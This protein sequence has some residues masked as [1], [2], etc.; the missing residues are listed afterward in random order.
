[1]SSSC[2]S[3]NRFNLKA[4]IISALIFSGFL[5]LNQINIVPQVFVN[6]N[7]F[8]PVFF[9][10]GL[11]ASVSSCNGLTLSLM[12]TV[13]DSSNSFLISRI[14]S[15]AVFGSILGLVGQYFK[16]SLINVSWMFIFIYL[17]LIFNGLK[18]V[19]LD[20]SC[21]SNFRLF[22]KIPKIHP[23][24]LGCFTFF[25][26]CGF[27]FTAQTL[28]L[29]SGNFFS[30]MAIMFLFAL[31][32]T[33]PLL[34]ISI[35]RFF[36]TPF[37]TN[38]A[39]FLIIFF[40][41]FSLYRQ[42]NINRS[43]ADLAPVIDGYQVIKMTVKKDGYYPNNFKIRSDLP[44]KW[45][46]KDGGVSA[47]SNT[48]ISKSLLDSPVIVTPYSVTTKNFN[49]PKKSGVYHFSCSM[50]MFNGSIEVIN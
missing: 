47:C 12:L 41:L 13:K 36:K 7:T 50:G 3:K 15:F 40:S 24:L 9:L 43:I 35:N 32:S 19:G 30:G 29:A 1:M 18:M 14:L 44:V 26:P 2:C 23:F 28:A 34:I 17:I 31:G 42:I 10:F 16:F 8:L 6:Q 27:T 33:I 21:L 11:L 37:F 46:I 39:G 5:F 49:P 45:E 25:L 20:C 48:I 22:K 38:I 4:L